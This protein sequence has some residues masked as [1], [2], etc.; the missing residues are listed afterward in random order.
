MSAVERSQ[1]DQGD[2]VRDDQDAVGCSLSSQIVPL[3][4]G[5]GT[6]AA[7]QVA[8]RIV[9]PVPYTPLVILKQS[10]TNP[11]ETGRKFNSS[12]ALPFNGQAWHPIV[13][14]D[15]RPPTVWNPVPR[16][17][18]NYLK[19]NNQLG[20]RLHVTILTAIRNHDPDAASKA[21]QQHMQA[22]LKRLEF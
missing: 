2:T 4:A 5:G 12:Y 21:M 17:K 16:T 9:G 10:K 7:N 18:L 3:Q 15:L 22:V 14:W 13:S 20:R 6:L 19:R 11:S 1:F 8:G